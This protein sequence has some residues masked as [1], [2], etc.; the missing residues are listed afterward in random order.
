M[1]LPPPPCCFLLSWLMGICL[2]AIQSSLSLLKSRTCLML[3]SGLIRGSDMFSQ[4]MVPRYS[5]QT[6]DIGQLTSANPHNTTSRTY[7]N[8]TDQNSNPG[9]KMYPASTVL[10][11]ELQQRQAE[12]YLLQC[13]METISLS[14]ILQLQTMGIFRMDL[15]QVPT[16]ALLG[17]SNPCDLI[18]ATFSS[19][20]GHAHASKKVKN[21][22][23]TFTNQY[24]ATDGEPHRG[25]GCYNGTAF[26][27]NGKKRKLTANSSVNEGATT[28][29]AE[30]EAAADSGGSYSG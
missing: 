28:S 1:L 10:L 16:S 30:R 13:Q 27:A 9:L 15:I 6:H 20:N 17:Q 24:T 26:R 11:G 5:T 22:D 18:E 4:L 29:G 2:L 12:P 21:E 19:D 14:P 23:G 25:T 3:M 7:S 8:S